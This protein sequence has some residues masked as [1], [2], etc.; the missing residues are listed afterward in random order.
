MAPGQG[1]APVRSVVFHSQLLSSGK[2]CSPDLLHLYYRCFNDWGPE[3][4][5]GSLRRVFLRGYYRK[6]Y[7]TVTN[8]H[9]GLK[10]G[11]ACDNLNQFL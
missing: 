10:S 4:S 5:W 3:R 8:N 9:L 1:T 6:A 7:P 2:F 11:P